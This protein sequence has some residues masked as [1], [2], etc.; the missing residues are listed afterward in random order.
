M[1]E[2]RLERNRKVR[3]TE[4]QREREGKRERERHSVTVCSVISGESAY[5]DEYSHGSRIKRCVYIVHQ[6]MI[7]MA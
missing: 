3:E 6:A 7:R 5:A 4:R 1:T 2:K